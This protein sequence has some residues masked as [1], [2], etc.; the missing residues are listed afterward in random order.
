MNRSDITV[1]SNEHVSVCTPV[2]TYLSML[3][4][5]FNYRAR[6]TCGPR[7]FTYSL[8]GAVIACGKWNFLDHHP[9]LTSGGEGFNL[10]KSMAWWPGAEGQLLLHHTPS[11]NFL[12]APKSEGGTK[13]RNCQCETLYKICKVQLV[14]KF[15]IVVILAFL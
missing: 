10:L 9:H 13:I 6:G 1:F 5:T 7:M 8:N 12:G 11:D 15:K 4:V 3:L 2:Y 14:K